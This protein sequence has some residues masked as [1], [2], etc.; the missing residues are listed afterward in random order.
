MDIL[1]ARA[2]FNPVSMS[3]ILGTS[4]PGVSKTYMLGW[5]AIWT[6]S[7]GLR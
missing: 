3:G 5:C 6:S 2:N 4:T 1:P 7:Q